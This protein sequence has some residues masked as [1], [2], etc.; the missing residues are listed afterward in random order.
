MKF[1]AIEVPGAYLVRIERLQDERGFFA[2]TF[3]EQEFRSAGL[4][5]RVSQASISYN[6]AQ[7]TLRGLHYQAAPHAET[8]IVR[9][10]RGA[11]WDVVVDVR[12]HSSTYLQ[13]TGVTLSADGDEMLYIPEGVAHGFL[14]LEPDTEIHYQMSV[15]Y[16]AENGRGIRWN[17]P[18]LGIDWPVAPRLMSNRD[19]GYPDLEP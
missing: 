4:N 18:A 8:K 19:R 2:R 6:A 3:C 13:W 11:I 17:D 10:T 15:P 16:S 5:P 14:T 9:C 1:R 7:G 12:P